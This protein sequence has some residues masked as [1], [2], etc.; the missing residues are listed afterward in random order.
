MKTILEV[1]E[2]SVKTILDKALEVYQK[3]HPNLNLTVAHISYGENKTLYIMIDSDET[4]S[5]IAISL[6]DFIEENFQ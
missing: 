1:I 6:R 3:K 2:N 5:I 4:K